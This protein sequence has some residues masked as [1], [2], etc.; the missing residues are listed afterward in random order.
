MP[1]VQGFIQQYAP[2]AASVGQRIGVAPDVLLGQWG[3]ETGWGK[4]VVPGTNN[5]GN[6]KGPGVAATD[7]QTGS[8]DQYR[9]YASPAAFGNDFANLIANRYQGAVGAGSNAAAYGNALAKGGYAEDS[10]YANKLA[11]AVGMVRKFGNAIA[12]AISGNANAAE[13]SPQ[14]MGGAPLISATGQQIM[15][16]V[17]KQ[18]SAAPASAPP[19]ST[20]DPLLDMAHGVMA[21]S[22]A[23][24]SAPAVPAASAQTAKPADDPLLA[25]ANSVMSA[26]DAPTKPAAAMPG[27]QAAPGTQ[28]HETMPLDILGGAVE[29]I[30]T[31]AT[32]T[33]GG[34]AG[35][36]V[37]LSSAAL[38]SSYDDAKATGNK[39]ADALTYQPQTQGG[40]QALAGLENMATGAKNAVMNSPVGPAISA[41]GKAYND[42]FVKGAPNAL[43]AT[44]N[45]QVPTI[46]GNVV[47]GK[48]G[49]AVVDGLAAA[50]NALRQAIAKPLAAADRVEPSLQPSGSAAL[51][52]PTNP[53]AGSAPTVSP[54]GSTLRGVGAA[55]ANPNPYAGQLTGEETARGGSS[56]F[57]QVKVAKNAGDVPEAEQAVRAQIANQILGP[58]NDAVRTG[59]I[60]GNEDTLRSEHTLSRSSDNTPEQIALRN[61]FAREQQALSDYAQQRIEATGA[62]PNLINN[63]QRGQVIADAVTGEGGLNEYLQQAKQQIYDRARQESGDNPIQTSHV[64][65][66]LND[67]QN[68]AEAARS[69]NARVFNAVS[70]LVNQARATGFRDPI[71]G[72]PTAPGSVAAWDA[73][74]KSNNMDWNEGNART[75]AGINRAIDQ[76]IAAAAGSDA[77]KLGDAIHQTQQEIAGAR[78]FRQIFGDTDSNGVKSGTA[79]EQIPSRLNNMPLDQWRHIYNTLDDLSRGQLHGAPDGL[80]P[81]P[82]ELQQAAGAARNEMSGALA[83]EVYEQGA[84]KAGVWNQNSVNKT[85]NSVIGQKILQTFSPD[86]VANFHTLNYGG[87]IMPGV[88]SYEGAGLQTQ[89]LS[90]GSLIEKHAGKVG[91]SIGGGLGGA[92]S[93]GAAASAGAG[94]GAWAGNKLAEGLAAKR[95]QGEAN[96]L[97]DSMRAN[98][99]RG[100]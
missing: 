28:P 3:L 31:L 16:Q 5:L 47:A 9:A 90:K 42:T 63:E 49:S 70:D 34:L 82:I 71:T 21:G 72:E 54:Q 87:Q 40:Q 15:P 4:S 25:M 60:T 78:G 73:L 2:V 53:A 20:G 76:D 6:I 65:A 55:Q 17:M 37:R 100:R 12:S 80:P 22:Q 64:E 92:I 27:T 8:N 19:A 95:L 96:Q 93:G 88:H 57:P 51:A 41:A 32:G 94:A 11:G 29:P 52:G 69:G 84:G 62:N 26:K 99:K 36:I 46:V 77:Y 81:I 38:G 74:R 44:I 35:G 61:Q 86:E 18:P 59:V 85:L 1:N 10:G 97:I 89:R 75:I 79:V 67:P 7:N 43:M 68:I 91:A 83:R 56:A 14:Q 13:P 45:S 30:A 23:A 39:V 98:S 58:E 33:L 50:P 24:S 48:A 66:F